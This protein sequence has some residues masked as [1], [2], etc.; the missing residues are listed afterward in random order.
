MTCP[1]RIH[2]ALLAAAGLAL[3][4]AADDV[5]LTNGRVFEDVVARTDGADVVVQFAGGVLRLP[6][7]RV[8]RIEHRDSALDEYLARRR[9]L[10]EADAGASEWLRLALW[11]RGEGLASGFREAARRAA[12]LEPDLE[13]LPPLMQALGYVRDEAG[14]PWLLPDD[15]MAR[16]GYVRHAGSWITAG[17]RAELLR[18]EAEGA[19]QASDASRDRALE[20]LAAAANIQAEAA[21]V[22]EENRRSAAGFPIHGTA[23]WYVPLPIVVPVP[24]AVPVPDEP[25]SSPV[26]PARRRG[27][28]HRGG[29]A[30]RVPGSLDS[31]FVPGRLNPD[32]APPPGRLDSR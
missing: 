29:F 32:A 9:V 10:A 1:R 27:G 18:A 22:R 24:I 3:S 30:D 5:H 13:G 4:A 21:R 15:L 14:G 25:P 19:R 31:A 28:T 16:R 23:G 7:S 8:A 20:L 11:A 17:E 26:P 6:A 2:F 12:S